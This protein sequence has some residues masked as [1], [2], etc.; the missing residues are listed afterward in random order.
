MWCTRSL[1]VFL[2]T[3]R[4][5]ITL[6]TWVWRKDIR[7]KGIPNMTRE[8]KTTKKKLNKY[9]GEDKKRTEHRHIYSL[10][11]RPP[12]AFKAGRFR[13]TALVYRW[14]QQQSVRFDRESFSF[15]RLFVTRARSKY[16][17]PENVYAFFLI[18]SNEVSCFYQRASFFQAASKVQ[19][20]KKDQP[21]DERNIHTHTHS[22]AFC[23]LH[24]SIWLHFSFLLL[25]FAHSFLF[26]P[27]FGVCE[28][29]CSH[30]SL[31]KGRK[32]Q[33]TILFG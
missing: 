15:I 9:S 23:L 31:K 21:K 6:E 29:I 18:Y 28:H 10:A 14:T 32:K 26:P 8:R 5:H 16:A 20:K 11:S 24:A 19:P 1:A 13:S 3:F 7:H 12:N 17:Y 4:H 27:L 30:E 2:S 25:V 33:Q 22:L